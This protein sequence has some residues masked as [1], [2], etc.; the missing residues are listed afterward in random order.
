MPTSFNSK[1]PIPVEFQNGKS[2]A[3]Y[4][5]FFSPHNAWYFRDEASAKETD[6]DNDGLRFKFSATTFADTDNNTGRCLQYQTYQ[7]HYPDSEKP[8]IVPYITPEQWNSGEAMIAQPLVECI[9]PMALT[10]KELSG[11]KILFWTNFKAGTALGSS[12][13]YDNGVI[14]YDYDVNKV[15]KFSKEMIQN[16]TFESGTITRAL[17][18]VQIQFEELYEVLETSNME[19]KLVSVPIASDLR[20]LNLITSDSPVVDFSTG[21][22]GGT[23]SGGIG[24]HSHTNNSDGGFSFAVFHPGTSLPLNIPWKR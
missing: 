20:I 22:G 5:E 11:A 1:T 14:K 7:S 3:F 21:G 24:R 15:I 18:S 9:T 16:Y 13:S 2:C 8:K 19:P 4:N 17:C 10:D 23:S 12:G 6:R